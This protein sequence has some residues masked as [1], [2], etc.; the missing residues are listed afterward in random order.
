MYLTQ[1]EKDIL[2][3]LLEK[4]INSHSYSAEKQRLLEKLKTKYQVSHYQIKIKKQSKKLWK[5]FIDLALS[6]HLMQIL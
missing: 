1:N 4:D 5:L 3:K 2:I 6:L